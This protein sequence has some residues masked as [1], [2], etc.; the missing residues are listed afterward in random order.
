MHYNT[1]GQMTMRGPRPGSKLIAIQTPLGSR[2]ILRRRHICASYIRCAYSLV[3]QSVIRTRLDTKNEHD[4]T[5]NMR[6]ARGLPVGW[7]ALS[8]YKD[9]RANEAI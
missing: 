2:N 5:V 7:K 3:M 4:R 6:L 9:E 1:A 8:G